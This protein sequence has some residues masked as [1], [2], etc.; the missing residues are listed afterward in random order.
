MKENLK[1]LIADDCTLMQLVMRTFLTGLHPQS[2]IQETSNLQETFT[3]LAQAE[4][5]L[6]LL[7]INMPNGDSTPDTVREILAKQ[8][9]IKVCMFS[10]NEKNTV[11]QYFLEAGAV[12][13]IQKNQHIRVNA[14]QVLGAITYS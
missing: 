5:D 10:S 4:F 3:A 7:D 12:G 8:K 2:E 9:S 6:L 13:Y 14:Q 11:E 1:I